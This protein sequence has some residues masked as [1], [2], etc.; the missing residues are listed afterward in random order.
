[1]CFWII[2][3]IYLFNELL[4][5]VIV[6]NDCQHANNCDMC[7]HCVQD[8]H[9]STVDQNQARNDLTNF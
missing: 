2:E 7:A 6:K 1:M 4:K 3:W 9:V 8:C 5:V